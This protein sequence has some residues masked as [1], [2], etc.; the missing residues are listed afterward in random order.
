MGTPGLP[1]ALS[2]A[3]KAAA[4]LLWCCLSRASFPAMLQ[5]YILHR[6]PGAQVLPGALWDPALGTLQPG[7]T[8][9]PLIVA[10]AHRE[11]AEQNAVLPTCVL[12]I[13][14]TPVLPGWVHGQGRKWHVR[15]GGKTVA[16]GLTL[17][18][19]RLGLRCC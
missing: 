7:G 17:A 4:T 3:G 19:Q 13:E 8:Q 5:S 1:A 15:N 11:E 12:S 6:G 16:L 14:Q 2:R 9:V 10:R 18:A